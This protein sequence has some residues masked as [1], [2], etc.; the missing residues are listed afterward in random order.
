MD[1][2]GRESVEL[3]LIRTVESAKD[4][5]LMTPPAQKIDIC[6]STRDI[7][8]ISEFNEIVSP[9]E[10]L[11]KMNVTADTPDLSEPDEP[12]PAKLELPKGTP[13]L[14]P[15]LTVLPPTHSSKSLID[16]PLH[17]KADGDLDDEEAADTGTMITCYF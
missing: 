15:S 5:R 11:V 4:V 10:L 3:P 8:D 17:L 14:Q 6:S 2:D 13:P 1:T 9:N 12:E 7:K 16:I